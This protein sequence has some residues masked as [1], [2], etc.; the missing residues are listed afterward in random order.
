MTAALLS[1]DRPA[2]SARSARH[3]RPGGSRIRRCTALVLLALPAL[4]ASCA[5]VAPGDASI[6]T[7]GAA[8]PSEPPPATA[9]AESP[10][11]APAA[12]ASPEQG[13]P[14]NPGYDQGEL[15][16]RL[17]SA[18]WS[19]D[20]KAAETL[21][22][23]GADVN[24]KD[25][26]VQSAYLIATSEGHLELLRLTLANGADVHDLDSWHGTGLIRAAERGHWRVVGE[27]IRAGVP[28]DHVNRVGYQAIHEAVIF[29]RD[30][31]SYHA[32]VRVLVAG[33]ADFSTP[34]MNE[35]QTPLQMAYAKGFPRQAA[36]LERLTTEPLP[37][38]PGAA[39]LSAAEAGDPDAVALA[40]RAGAAPDT[41]DASGRTAS[42]IAEE[43]MH[44]A[45][46]QLLRALG[47]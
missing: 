1:D 13:A 43:R 2:P 39:L 22:A 9:P 31:E 33:G 35:R 26:T 24:A 32:T 47:G 36:L 44:P 38:D 21:I 28:L 25:D 19:D 3:R 16:E 12:E 6:G 7:G 30:D 41:R 42:E 23:W 27:L 34:S 11:E 4:L 45:A 14:T 17:R 37:Q 5:P 18:A 8:G 15:D 20:V 46:A 40:L 29:G 10:A